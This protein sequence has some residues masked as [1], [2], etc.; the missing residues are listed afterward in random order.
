M[1]A[2]L[3]WN[4]APYF[5]KLVETNRLA[6]KNEMQ[7]NIGSGL[8]S[9]EQAVDKFL[10]TLCFLYLTESSDG[11]LVTENSPN[12]SRVK[13]IFMAMR[14]PENDMDARQLCMDTLNEIF[15]QFASHINRERIRLHS[16]GIYI[17]PDIEFHEFGEYYFSGCAA[18]YFHIKFTTAVDLRYNPEEWQ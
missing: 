18:M 7:F 2:Q 1:H 10:D 5:K 4:A 17:N 11:S 3:N 9:F 12:A 6:V 13:T 15:R 16:L 14:H 8:K